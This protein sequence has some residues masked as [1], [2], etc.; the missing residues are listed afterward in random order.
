MSNA[1]GAHPHRRPG[2]RL[3]RQPFAGQVTLTANLAVTFGAN[4]VSQDATDEQQRR[5]AGRSIKANT[6]FG[7]LACAGN[8]PAPTNAGQPNTAGSKTGQCVGL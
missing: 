8:N 6:F 2:R 4:N 7:T 5:R 3:R 1:A